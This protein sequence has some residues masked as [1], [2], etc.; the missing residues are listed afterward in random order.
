MRADPASLAILII[1]FWTLFFIERYRSFGAIQVT[2]TTLIAIVTV[3]HWTKGPPFS[4][5]SNTS[6]YT[7]GYRNM[8]KLLPIFEARE[9]FR[10][11]HSRLFTVHSNQLQ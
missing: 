6:G 4:G 7:H 1:Y 10:L 8:R 2:K 3:N 5:F 11:F 9:N